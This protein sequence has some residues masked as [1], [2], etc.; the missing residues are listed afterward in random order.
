MFCRLY[1]CN[2]RRPGSGY[3]DRP[4]DVRAHGFAVPDLSFFLHISTFTLPPHTCPP[5]ALLAETHSSTGYADAKSDGW[6][7]RKKQNGLMADAIRVLVKY[8][9]SSTLQDDLLVQ[10]KDSTK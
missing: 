9:K 8:R 1:Q 6:V 7:E 2:I 3:G 10:G 4:G 5:Q